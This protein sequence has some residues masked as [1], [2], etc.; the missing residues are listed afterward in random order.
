MKV[1]VAS[2]KHATRPS[3]RAAHGYSVLDPLPKP[4]FAAQ[5]PLATGKPVG[6]AVSSTSVVGAFVVALWESTPLVVDS[7]VSPL[8][9]DSEE[10]SA[11]EESPPVESGLDELVELV[12]EDVEVEVD[13]LLVEDELVVE[14]LL[15]VVVDDDVNSDEGTVGSTVELG[16]LVVASDDCEGTEG[17]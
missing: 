1:A 5:A 10:F 9:T 12:D 8:D 4:V 17:R 15:E 7:G 2:A 3:S 16:P 14:L 11:V 13:E 6:T